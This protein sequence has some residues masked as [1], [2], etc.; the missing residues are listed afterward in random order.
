MWPPVGRTQA[1][2]SQAVVPVWKAGPGGGAGALAERGSLRLSAPGLSSTLPAEPLAWR[3]GK[4]PLLKPTQRHAK[5]FPSQGSAPAQGCRWRTPHPH[6]ALGG[7]PGHCAGHQGWRCPRASPQRC[8]SLSAPRVFIPSY[9]SRVLLQLWNCHSANQSGEGCPLWLK[10]RG[11]APPLHNSTALDCQGRSPCRLALERPLWQNWYY[12]LVEKHLG[13]ASQVGFQLLAQLKGELEAWGA[14]G[15]GPRVGRPQL[16]PVLLPILGCVCV[17]LSL[18]GS[19]HPSPKRHSSL[20]RSKG[21]SEDHAG[22]TQSVG[23][24]AQLEPA[25]VGTPGSCC[26]QQG[27][28]QAG[29]EG[30][31]RLPWLWP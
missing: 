13:V 30:H 9:T 23:R 28:P 7:N 21:P 16:L 3:A 14:G 15:T 31:S 1:G 5:T 26:P 27:N 4:A 29:P 10:V 12:V 6:P 20:Q 25:R 2:C 19:F 17:W 22:K 8:P 11:K 18:L 24:A